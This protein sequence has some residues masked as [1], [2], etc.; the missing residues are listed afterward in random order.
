[1]KCD[2]IKVPVLCPLRYISERNPCYKL[3]YPSSHAGMLPRNMTYAD[4][5]LDLFSIQLVGVS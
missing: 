1:M 4:R 5:R 3:A 2:L